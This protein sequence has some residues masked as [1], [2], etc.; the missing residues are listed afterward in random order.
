MLSDRMKRAGV[1][2][3]AKREERLL[4]R[5]AQQ[6]VLLS[7]LHHTPHRR[8]HQHKMESHLQVGWNTCTASLPVLHHSALPAANQ[9]AG[10]GKSFYGMNGKDQ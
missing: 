4:N 10:S 2:W 7:L 3:M 9:K 5:M 1:V 6:E 8:A